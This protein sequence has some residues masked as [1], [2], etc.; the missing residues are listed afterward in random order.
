MIDPARDG[1]RHAHDGIAERVLGC[2]IE[3]A[4][5][6]AEEFGREPRDMLGHFLGNGHRALDVLL[7]WHAPIV[8]RSGPVAMI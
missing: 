6:D 7:V 3:R 8:H 2:A 5:H 1:E 4:S